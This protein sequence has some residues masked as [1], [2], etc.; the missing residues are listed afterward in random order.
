MTLEKAHQKREMVSLSDA[1]M[2]QRS[3]AKLA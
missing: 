3:K 1:I 2:L